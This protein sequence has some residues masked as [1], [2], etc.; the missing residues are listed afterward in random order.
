MTTHGPYDHEQEPQ[1]DEHKRE[2]SSGVT[3]EF[4][5]EFSDDGTNS[6]AVRVERGGLTVAP[7]GID[8]IVNQADAPSCST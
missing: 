3:E 5:A 4:E 7:N 2:D 6:A 1:T 8:G